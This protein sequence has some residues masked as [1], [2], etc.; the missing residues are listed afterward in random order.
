ML[1]NK[2]T[3]VETQRRFKPTDGSEILKFIS[4]YFKIDKM[5]FKPIMNL[6][7]SC[8]IRSYKHC[9]LVKIKYRSV[10]L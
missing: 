10:T 8:S 5:K 6:D 2:Y 9:V 3:I 4:S 7:E 1:G